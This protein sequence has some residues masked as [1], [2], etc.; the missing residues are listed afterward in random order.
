MNGDR[1]TR[2]YRQYGPAI[3]ARCRRILGDASG[4]EDATHE[5]FM[6]VHKHL[7]AVP[8]TDAALRWIYRI[9]T[10]YC[11][12]E[13]RNRKHRPNLTAELPELAAPIQLEDWFTDRDLVGRLVRLVPERLRSAAWLYHVDGI[14]QD[15]VAQVLGVS[16]RTV[17]NDLKRFA[18]E[19]RRL[20]TRDAA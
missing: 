8:D 1:L 13:L 7:A 9:A 10:N 2:L 4:A 5:T 12:N 11:L 19:A 17:V 15:E 18:S 14:P 20:L 6:R 3:Y 16:R